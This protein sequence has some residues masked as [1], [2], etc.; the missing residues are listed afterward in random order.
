MRRVLLALLGAFV[1]SLAGPAFAHAE[2]IEPSNPNNYECS[3]N[4][5]AGKAEAGGE[6][7][8]VKYTFLC[9]G[10]ITGYQVQTQL[11][12][13]GIEGAPLVTNHAGTPLND[14]FSCSGAFPGYALNCVGSST[15]EPEEK[16]TGQFEIGWKLCTEPRVDALLTVTYA[17]LEKGV[18]TQAISGPFDLG[19]PLGCPA[20]AQSGK[21]RLTAYQ[22]P[23]PKSKKDKK[24]K[25]AG[26]SK[27]GKSDKKGT[28]K[29]KSAS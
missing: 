13:A 23:E 25:G 8:P 17:Y 26:K 16:I 15:T 14:T 20:T 24:G 9:D 4:L 28:K 1:C 12:I 10:Q 27:K 7:T 22:G 6:E 21:N 18:I 19:R 29:H 2:A 5:S 3:G 11:P